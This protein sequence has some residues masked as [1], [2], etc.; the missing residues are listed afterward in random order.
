MNEQ[1][2]QFRSHDEKEIWLDTYNAAIKGGFGAII[3]I[4]HADTAVAAFRH[5]I[6]HLPP[7]D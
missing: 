2:K 3:A 1:P 5:R 4:D 7:S 6:E